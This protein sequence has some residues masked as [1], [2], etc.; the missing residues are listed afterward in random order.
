MKSS[1]PYFE[2]LVVDDEPDVIDVTKVALKNTS[3]Y[4]S[5]IRVIPCRSKQSTLEL[6]SEKVKSFTIAI[7][8]IDIRMEGEMS[9]LELC[10]YI[11]YALNNRAINLYIR[12]GSEDAGLEEEAIKNYEI[13][14]YL[15]LSQMTRD[16]LFSIIAC[17][18]K[19]YCSKLLN[20]TSLEI[21]RLVINSINANIS[22][23]QALSFYIQHFDSV[24]K[25]EGLMSGTAV[26]LDGE[27][28]GGAGTLKSPDNIKSVQ[29]SLENSAEITHSDTIPDAAIMRKDENVMFKVGSLTWIESG[30]PDVPELLL[31]QVLECRVVPVYQLYNLSKKLRRKQ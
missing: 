20:K 5:D 15:S 12:T 7:G 6:L 18:I 11:R 22:V 19:N 25:S 30:I 28:I 13:D 2:V 14:G 10:N 27:C 21:V 4:G 9:G 23:K 31:K 29:Q 24:H 3:I 8:L 17:G 26:F 1:K 16:K